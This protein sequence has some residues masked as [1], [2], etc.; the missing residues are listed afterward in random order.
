MYFI[1]TK[2]KLRIFVP[3]NKLKQSACP[4]MKLFGQ[5]CDVSLH[6]NKFYATKSLAILILVVIRLSS[7]FFLFFFPSVSPG[8]R[9][10]YATVTDSLHL[11]SSVLVGIITSPLTSSS[12][13]VTQS[14]S[15][16]ISPFDLTANL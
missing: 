1:L 2:T 8:N 6:E 10:I 11:R 9:R 4:G 13:G 12:V 16:P 7:S 5:L 15:R 14:R 3:E